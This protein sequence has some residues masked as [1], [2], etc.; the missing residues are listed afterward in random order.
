MVIAIKN[1]GASLFSDPNQ[2]QQVIGE[3]RTFHD[4]LNDAE[5]KFPLIHKLAIV[6]I[7]SILKLKRQLGDF[8]EYFEEILKLSDRNRNPGRRR[9]PRPVFELLFLGLC[10][11]KGSKN[12]QFELLKTLCNPEKENI[13]PN[14]AKPD[15]YGKIFVTHEQINSERFFR[16]GDLLQIP[17]DLTYTSQWIS[18]NRD[19]FL[20]YLIEIYSDKKSIG[21]ADEIKDMLTDA[22]SDKTKKNHKILK[23]LTKRWGFDG[24]NELS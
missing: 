13:C 9:L 3:L 2:Y 21:F 19:V 22:E 14:E 12:L 7:G 18:K 5:K 16:F 20:N 8:L 17:L 1:E 11:V 23:I 24:F 15:Y 4:Y 10:F 6:D